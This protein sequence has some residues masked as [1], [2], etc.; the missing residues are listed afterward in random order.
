MSHQ[1]LKHEVRI[2]RSTE[3]EMDKLPMMIRIGWLRSLLW[4]TVAKCTVES[5][6]L[7]RTSKMNEAKHWLNSSLKSK[8]EGTL[9]LGAFL[10]LSGWLPHPGTSSR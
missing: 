2:F 6:G 10:G 3:K 1:E 4:V 9:S 8:L 7:G 5:D